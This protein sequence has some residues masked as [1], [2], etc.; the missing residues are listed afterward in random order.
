MVHK[1]ATVTAQ[2]QCLRNYLLHQDTVSAEYKPA[3]T[4][5]ASRPGHD[6]MIKLQAERW[7][8][9]LYR[10]AGPGAMILGNLDPMPDRSCGIEQIEGKVHLHARFAKSA[11]SVEQ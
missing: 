10:K 9:D 11:M 7:N 1:T 2:D 4:V 3:A 5:R 8:V 6:L